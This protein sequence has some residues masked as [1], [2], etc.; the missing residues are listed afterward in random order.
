MNSPAAQKRLRTFLVWT[1]LLVLFVL[2]YHAI[3]RRPALPPRQPTF[4]EVAAATGRISSVRVDDGRVL[5]VTLT[6]GSTFTTGGGKDGRA[7]QALTAHLSGAKPATEDNDGSSTLRT[8]AIV[9][10][11]LAALFIFFRRMYGRQV[12]SFVS[13]SKTK[14]RLLPDASTRTFADVGGCMEAKVALRDVVDFL[15]D[16]KKWEAA[17]ARPPRGILLEGP[18]GCG[19]TL[20]VK[21]LAGEA[22]AKFFF[23]SASEFVELFV[24]VG[25]ARVR[26]T[27]ETAVK[28]APSVIFIDE[29]DAVGRHRGSGLGG[30]HDEREQTLNQLLVCL[31]GVQGYERVVVLAATNRSDIL[32]AALLRPGRFDRRIHIGS[33]SR[34]E[35]VEILGIHTRKK[36]LAADVSLETLADMTDGLNGA[37]IEGVTNEAA[38]LAVRRSAAAGGAPELSMHDFRS[39]LAQ[40]RARRGGF[41]SVDALLIAS[42]SQVQQSGGRALARLVL[43]DGSVVSGQ[44]LWANSEFVKLRRDG[45]GSEVVLP[46]AQVKALETLDGTTAASAEDEVSDPWAA[47]PPGIA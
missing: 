19:K 45:T 15:Q 32:D 3:D 1:L 17:G 9:A 31:D 37:E 35:R 41:D 43:V 42:S 44:L 40:H 8:L 27:F 21:A 13:F 36:P 2:G 26:D 6:D 46:K 28:E 23:V 11:V 33:P 10:V 7:L 16:P 47:R 5:H 14:A 4:L 20:L 25:A 18:A 39:A 29:L 22:K 34:S 30:S 12:S 38:I 24:G